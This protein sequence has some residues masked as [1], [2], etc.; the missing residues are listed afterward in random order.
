MSALKF[1]YFIKG[2][3]SHNLL[4]VSVIGCI[5]IAKKINFY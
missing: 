4:D 3:N 5:K 2:I 1:I